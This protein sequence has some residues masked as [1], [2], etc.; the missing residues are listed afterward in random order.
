VNDP[1][2]LAITGASGAP[3]WRRLLAVLLDA[4]REVHLT[5]SSHAD[6]V[7]RT[8]LQ[9]P[10][11]DVLEELAER[12]G[13]GRLRTFDAHDFRAPMASGS[14]RYAG[15]AIVPC[16]LGT[17]SRVA[18]GVSNDLVTRAA[19]VMLKERRKLVLLF[20]ETPL[21]LVHLENMVRVT[22]AGAVVMP[23]APGF[24]RRPKDIADLVDFVVQRICAQ[25]AVD[26]ELVRP[27]GDELDGGE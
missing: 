23:A 25:L 3:Y 11:A 24:Y 10:L 20:R 27:W 8:E 2:A 14:A 19:D 4:G 22:Q 15:M 17:L 1:I 7:C 26:V 16:S 18:T 13:K 6:E 21:S 5:W 9:R 12:Q